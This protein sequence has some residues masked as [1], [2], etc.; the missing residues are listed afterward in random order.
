MRNFKYILLILVFPIQLFGQNSLVRIDLNNV[1][2]AGEP[3][4]MDN[5]LSVIERRV[6]YEL[7]SY[8]LAKATDSLVYTSLHPM[9]A[10]LHYSFADHRPVIISPDMIWLLITQSFA[11][12]IDQ[13]PEKYR[14]LIVGFKY[15]KTIQ[16]VRNDFK[17]GKLENP[18]HETFPIFSDS[19]KV[20]IGDSMH[21]SLIPTFSTTRLAEKYA[22]EI[23]LMDATSNYFDYDFY[24]FCGIPYIILQG[25][26][27]DWE[28]IADNFDFFNSYDLE[29]WVNR[30]KPII[31]E[32][33]QSSQGVHNVDF[34]KNVYKWHEA[35]GGN[36]INGWIADFFLYTK[37]SDKYKINELLLISQ[38]SLVAEASDKHI[39]PR[40]IHGNE[41]PNGL[42]KVDFSWVHLVEPVDTF[43]MSLFAG[44]I[45]IKQNVNTLELEP[46]ISYAI[47]DQKNE[48]IEMDNIT[49][50]D[51]HQ[52]SCN[53]F[54]YHAMNINQEPI[55][56]SDTNYNDFRK[57]EKSFE[58]YLRQNVKEYFPSKTDKVHYT[59]TFTVTRTGGIRDITID[60]S[61]DK[62]II[63][64]LKNLI[65]DT[66]VWK[67]AVKNGK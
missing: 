21:K 22:F 49:I 8:E 66:E 7:E 54:L 26:P 58:K 23:S 53:S 67:P 18:W 40:G 65:K 4:I 20:Y 5:Y 45:G 31:N 38:D 12:H 2:L 15:K 33:Y 10:A 19:I 50:I 44:F 62:A 35:S 32:I 28:W 61:A 13:N 37:Q 24:T 55:F 11:I 34:W 39:M 30:L 64:Y 14:D 52:P 29:F 27:S 59:I 51:K 48:R 16:I 25:E 63:N 47:V 17:K 9:I 1:D 6:G 56:Q 46:E 3:L 60:S 57:S 43:E 42:S 36:I 41:F